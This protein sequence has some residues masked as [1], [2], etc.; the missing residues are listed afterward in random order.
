MIGKK[1]F[2]CLKVLKVEKVSKLWYFTVPYGTGTKLFL[3]YKKVLKFP[4]LL[5]LRSKNLISLLYFYSSTGP[6]YRRT[7]LKTQTGGSDQREQLQLYNTGCGG[8][9][10][11]NTLFCR[12]STGRCFTNSVI[13]PFYDKKV[14]PWFNWAP[15]FSTA[16]NSVLWIRTCSEPDLF[17]SAPVRII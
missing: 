2:I 6:G 4:I 17:G 16:M 15:N 7:G 1:S 3:C 12:I 14:K 13:F 8:E 11:Q 9:N 10:F 5:I